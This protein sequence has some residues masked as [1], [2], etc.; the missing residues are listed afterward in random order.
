MADVIINPMF[1]KSESLKKFCQGIGF[2]YLKLFTQQK[3]ENCVQIEKEKVVAIHYKLTSSDGQTLDSS[4]GN[5]PLHY[6]H[7]FGNII[8]GLEEELEGKKEGDK[9][10]VTI[11]PEKAYGVRNDQN[12]LQVKKDQFEGVEEVKIGMQVQTQSEKGV[13]LFT[14]SK[15]FGD[16]VILDG[17]HPLAG[18]TLS[19]DVEVMDIRDASKE[20]LE[21][22]HVHGPGGHHH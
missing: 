4:E 3:K 13:Q 17:N 21:H 6:L 18:E 20:E 16:T 14:V 11:P 22:G 15:M 5:D 12:M 1:Q 9:L 7:G 8:P 19:F 10:S 2:L